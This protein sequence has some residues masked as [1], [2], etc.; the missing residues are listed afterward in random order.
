MGVRLIN[1]VSA[2]DDVSM[3]TPGTPLPAALIPDCTKPEAHHAA[4]RSAKANDAIFVCIAR[5]GQRWKVELDAMASSGPTIPDQA[6]TVL[7]SA[8]EA[9]VSAGTATQANIGPDYIS[10]WAIENEERAREIA[11]AF[12]AALLGLQQLYTAVPSQRGRA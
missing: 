3:P 7:Q 8:V 9:L 5:Q 4:Y 1:G 11:A 12:H 6:V 2:C 10:M